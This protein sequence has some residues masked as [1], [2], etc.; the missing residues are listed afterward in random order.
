MSD[1]IAAKIFA[2]VVL[3]GSALLWTCALSYN[4]WCRWRMR[5]TWRQ[6]AQEK[7]LE[8]PGQH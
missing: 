8:L 3:G 5:Q 6:R 1:L 7:R 2:G 4:A